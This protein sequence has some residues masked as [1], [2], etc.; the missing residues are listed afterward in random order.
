MFRI[1]LAQKNEKN[2]R[3]IKESLSERALDLEFIEVFPDVEDV[4]NSVEMLRPDILILSYEMGVDTGFAVIEKLK[5]RKLF[6]GNALEDKKL[7][8]TMTSKNNRH[9]VI[10]SAFKMGVSDFLVEPLDTSSLLDGIDAIMESSFANRIKHIQSNAQE[11][12]MIDYNTMAA[13]T[14]FYNVMF[15][16]EYRKTEDGKTSY[17][18][19]DEAGFIVIFEIKSILDKDSVDCYDF[20]KKLRYKINKNMNVKLGPVM[21]GRMGVYIQCDNE[22]IKDAIKMRNYLHWSTKEVYDLVQ[23]ELKAEVRAGV[24]RVYPI[25]KVG[26]SYEEALRAVTEKTVEKINVYKEKIL[27]KIVDVNLYKEKVRRL[28]EGIELGNSEPLGYFVDLLDLIDGLDEEEKYNRIMVVLMFVTYAVGKESHLEAEAKY[29]VDDF[30][31]NLELDKDNINV[32]AINRFNNILKNWNRISEKKHSESVKYCIDYIY[33]NYKDEVVLKD[34]AKECG[35]SVQH[36]S[37]LFREETGN[38]FVDYLNGFRI[39]KAKELMLNKKGTIKEICF[40]VGYNDPNYFS[41]IFKKITGKTPRQFM[42]EYGA[43]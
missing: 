25:K 26:V 24:G 12:K 40:E 36:L 5:E 6:G 10:R 41:R 17:S 4:V 30:R 27:Q 1:L 2:N 35:I 20:Q 34:V 28:I 43:D 33:G 31:K 11:R 21:N 38:N 16:E 15:N 8:I 42:H 9:Q 29:Y 32:A 22:Y 37:K 19:E 3:I 14:F 13:Y 23:G 18:D 39:K 7:Y